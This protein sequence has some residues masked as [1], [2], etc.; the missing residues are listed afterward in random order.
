MPIVNGVEYDRILGSQE[1][2]QRCENELMV[3]QLIKAYH[4]GYHVITKI[5]AREDYSDFHYAMEPDTSSPI[6]R[7]VQAKKTVYHY[8]TPLVYYVRVF[9]D[10]YEKLK[11]VGKEQSCDA[12]YVKVI[13][14]EYIDNV[15]GFIRTETDRAI[16]NL[17]NVVSHYVK[18]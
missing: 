11:K 17:E 4:S 16:Y 2:K 6:G 12:A 5:Q 3:G 13:T 9:N 15:V 7:Y 10:K 1:L 18:E 8:M 14:K